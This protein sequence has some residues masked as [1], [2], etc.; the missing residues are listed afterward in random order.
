MKRNSLW[1]L[2]V[3]LALILL[4]PACRS[5]SV[6]EAEPVPSTE[7]IP[8]PTPAERVAGT[9][10]PAVPEGPLPSILAKIDLGVP[11]GNGYEPLALTLDEERGLAYVLNSESDQEDQ[12]IISVL[13]LDQAEVVQTIPL[14]RR[15]D[16]GDLL[17][18]DGRLYVLGSDEWTEVLDP[19]TGQPLA[20]LPSAWLGASDGDGGLILA[21][22]E[23]LHVVDT[24][25]IQVTEEIPLVFSYTDLEDLAADSEVERIYVALWQQFLVLDAQGQ[26]VASYDLEGT[27]GHRLALDRDSHRIYLT[28]AS[29][30]QCFD[31]QTGAP[32]ESLTLG[33][34]LEDVSPRARSMVIDGQ[35]G[36]LYVAYSLHAEWYGTA[37]VEAVDLESGQVLGFSATPTYGAGQLALDRA[38]N[39]LLFIDGDYDVVRL[40]QA[41]PLELYRMVNLGVTV[42][43]AVLDPQP[44][45]LYVSDNAGQVHVFDTESQTKL[46]SVA[47]GRYLALDRARHRLYAGDDVTEVVALDSLSMEVTGRVSQA[48]EPV[49][50]PASGEIYII[51][52]SVYV[53]DP[54]SLT[55]TGDLY[56]DLG[57]PYPECPGCYYTVVTG[58]AVDPTG[59]EMYPITYTPWPGKPSDLIWMAVDAHTDRVYHMLLKGGYDRFG[60]LSL[61]Q[62]MAALNGGESPEVWLDG[63]AGEIAVDGLAGRLY[64]SWEDR[65]YVL[66][67]DNLEVIGRMD[68]EYLTI[69]AIDSQAGRL[70]GLDGDQLVVLSTSGGWPAKYGPV[71]VTALSDS[72]QAIY[73][74][75]AYA[76]D[77]TLFVITDDVYRSDDDGGS[78]V[79]LADGLFEGYSSSIRLAL[80]PDFATDGTLFA[81][82]GTYGQ[83]LGEGVYRSTDRGDAWQPV[84][85]GLNHL[86]VQD[87]A[88]SPDY[89][90]DGTLLAYAR[91]QQVTPSESG[92]SLFRSTDSGLS[93]TLV[94]TRTSGASL[95]SPEELLP[96]GPESSLLRFRAN[97]TYDAQSER[98][99]YVEQTADGGGT[100]EEILAIYEPRLHTA[101]PS[102]DFDEDKTI[103]GLSDYDLFRSTDGGET[104]ERW[105]DERLAGRDFERRLTVMAIVSLPDERRHQVFVGTGAGELWSLDPTR[106]VW[107]SML[108]PTATSTPSPTAMPTPAIPPSATETPMTAPPPGFYRPEGV[109]GELWATDVDLRQALG[110]AATPQ[111]TTVST[112]FQAFEGGTMIWREDA[113]LIYVLSNDGSWAVFDD[114]WTPDEPEQDPNIVPPEGLL[115]PIRGFGKVWRNNPEL[116]VGLGW[117]LEEEAGYTSPVQTFEKGV[118]IRIGDTTYALVLA[119]GRPATWYQR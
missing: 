4:L 95:P 78:W 106:L 42:M 116:Q 100:W 72:V 10:T 65:L 50:N 53:A 103:Y 86:R 89:A 19:A 15:S 114:T 48:G 44:K 7:V 74:S 37:R 115:Q 69:A 51:N 109:F 112:A 25:S 57:K 84:W 88:L 43:D 35:A 98:V 56:P 16:R 58:L 22:P 36:R 6:P 66:H 28:E 32:L 18:V 1:L 20:T 107:E 104:W 33:P 62:D 75:P 77:Q 61:Y 59:Q 8:S 91:Y 12:G 52:L 82:R 13:D 38:G 93:W 31:G 46:T 68:N 23:G 41:H 71:T 113:R 9:P 63:L 81:F 117:A 47:G 110:W 60:L 96:T 34:G 119:A 76:S 49:V 94:M 108:T 111:A 5:E 87:V 102:S 26:Q 39:R 97:C 14:D 101:L 11:V 67:A 54:E 118:L 17:F 21:G 45:L 30:V 27:G 55:V 80:S 73:P 29:Q 24:A 70:Y 90:D 64:L 2:M 3:A 105:S 99:C 79:R 83:S 40:F 85:K 92:T